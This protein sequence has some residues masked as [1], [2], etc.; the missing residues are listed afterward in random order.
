MKMLRAV[1]WCKMWDLWAE[2]RTNP[3]PVLETTLGRERQ[4]DER[5]GRVVIDGL[6]GSKLT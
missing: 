5:R 2:R 3:S 4:A 1:S 6:F